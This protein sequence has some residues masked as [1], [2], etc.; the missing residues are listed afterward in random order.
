MIGAISSTYN[1]IRTTMPQGSQWELV[2]SVAAEFDN[3][4]FYSSY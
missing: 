2:S 3:L 1:I 4:M